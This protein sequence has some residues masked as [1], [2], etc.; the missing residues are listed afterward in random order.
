MD[1][2]FYNDNTFIEKKRQWLK[3]CIREEDEFKKR[4][5]RIET[6]NYS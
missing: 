4:I 6:L 2:F 1:V 3:N 5:E